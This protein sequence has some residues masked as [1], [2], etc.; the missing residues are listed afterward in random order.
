M[1]ARPRTAKVTLACIVST[2]GALLAQSPE[3]LRLAVTRDGDTTKHEYSIQPF[4]DPNYRQVYR[5]AIE[6]K[7]E[8]PAEVRSPDRWT[9]TVVPSKPDDL[10]GC[11][12]K[13][14]WKAPL[15]GATLPVDGFAMRYTGAAPASWCAAELDGNGREMFRTGPDAD[16]PG[17]P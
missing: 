7:G 14:E 9:A 6:V 11:K 8:R 3:F 5:L 2:A 15:S 4:G 13:V 12:W 16:T 1:T 17:V 10:W